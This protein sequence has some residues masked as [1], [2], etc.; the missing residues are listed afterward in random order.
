MPTF[1]YALEMRAEPMALFQLSQDYA[2]RLAWDPFLREARL[3]DGARAPGV[4]VRVWCVARG[5]LGMETEYVTYDPPRV[6][7]VRMTRGP[8]IL[9]RFAGTWRFAAVAPGVTRVS[10]QYALAARPAWLRFALDPLLAAVLG[11]EMRRRLVALRRAVE[12]TDILRADGAARVV[13]GDALDT[14]PTR[15][16]TP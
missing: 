3:L 12:T 4:G 5:G 16:H 11:R 8:R 2:R 9:R 14:Q 6:V 10:F 15:P 1:R 7:A 13:E